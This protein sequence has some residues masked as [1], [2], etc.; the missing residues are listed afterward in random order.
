MTPT[1]TTSARQVQR[2]LL[3]NG[4]V[5]GIGLA[6]NLDQ[7]VLHELLQWHNLYVHAGPFWRIFIDGLFHLTMVG[8][9]A[10][11]LGSV[12]AWA[13]RHPQAWRPGTLAAGVL[14]GAGGFNLFDGTVNHKLLRLHQVREGAAD[15]WVY[16]AVFIGLAAV[17]FAAGWWLWGRERT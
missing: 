16:D 12:A 3:L 15:L 9:L 13:R 4:I 11:G 6:G 10:A 8:V 14:L 17:V 1:R 2:D 7:I 5:V